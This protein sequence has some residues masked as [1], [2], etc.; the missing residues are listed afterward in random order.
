M[1]ALSCTLICYGYRYFN[2][3]LVTTPALSIAPVVAVSIGQKYKLG[4][5]DIGD[6][7]IDKAGRACVYNAIDLSFEQGKTRACRAS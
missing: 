2:H 4:A 5:G 6:W 7:F 1:F 3:R